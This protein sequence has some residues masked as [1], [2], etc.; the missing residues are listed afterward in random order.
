MVPSIRT[1]I[2]GSISAMALFAGTL[3]SAGCSATNSPSG[4]SPR[5]AESSAASSEPKLPRPRI[6]LQ[7]LL[8]AAKNGA[9]IHIP[10]GEYVIEKGLTIEDK[11]D[12]LIVA[13]GGANI[14]LTDVTQDV[15]AIAQS[16]K[17][18]IRNLHVR[19][20]KPLQEYECHGAVL[21]VSRSQDVRVQNCDLDGCGA[22]GVAAD[23]VAKLQVQDCHIH[24]NTFTAIYLSRCQEVQIYGCRIEDNRHFLQTL[25]VDDLQMGDIIANRNGGYWRDADPNPGM[26]PIKE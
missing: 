24:N 14:F 10:H 13:D 5:A 12:L 3:V 2:L 18:T 8:T 4:A 6:D 19:H 7:P 21:R 23:D 26:K 22:I 17:I 9:T 11:S 25:E 1:H 15:L 20:L 16:R